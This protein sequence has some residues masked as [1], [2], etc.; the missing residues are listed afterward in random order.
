MH[1]ESR[2]ELHGIEGELSA[3]GPKIARRLFRKAL[4]AVGV[5]W[6]EEARSRVAVDTGD[7]QESIDFVIQT[8]SGGG[9]VT[10]GP[11]FDAR[12]T[13]GSSDQSQSPGLYGMFV[14]FGRM[15]NRPMAAQ[16]FLRPTFD[17][18]AEKAVGLFADT[19]KDGLAEAVKD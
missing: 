3:L 5:M 17:T 10:V 19:L 8:H 15:K 6:K 9:K 16:P 11:T 12:G 7:L 2:V 14:E 1:V 13:E 4:K 18:T